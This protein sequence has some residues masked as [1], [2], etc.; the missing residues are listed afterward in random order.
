MN[1]EDFNKLA[2]RGSISQPRPHIGEKPGCL[3]TLTLALILAALLAACRGD[4]NKQWTFVS[5]GNGGYTYHQI[6]V[7]PAPESWHMGCEGS[8]FCKK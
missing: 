5:D 2:H 6:A 8:V 3:T 1:D 7:T 4:E